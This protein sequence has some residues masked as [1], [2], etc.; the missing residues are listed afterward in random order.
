MKKLLFIL[1]AFSTLVST[2]MAQMDNQVVMNTSELVSGQGVRVVTIDTYEGSPYLTDD[3]VKGY[4]LLKDGVRTQNI[5]LRYNMTNNQVE[6][7]R[8]DE[9]YGIKGAKID[10]FIII[11]RP[12]DIVFKNGFRNN[13]HFDGD[14]LLRVMYD[15]TNKLLAQHKSQLMK[16]I[17]SYGVAGDINKY[18]SDTDYYLITVD[19]KV[20]EIELKKD[21]I[22]NLLP[23]HHKELLKYVN[24]NNL[25]FS[26]KQNLKK[27]LYYYDLLEKD[28]E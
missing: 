18:V 19:G 4:I 16:N 28:D 12:F 2:A 11:A 7:L 1:F 15:G 10:G 5:L 13:K 8:K 24:K 14:A 25:S 17:S 23:H 26:N 21:D 3:F 27:I 22:L 20:H 6:F 9:V